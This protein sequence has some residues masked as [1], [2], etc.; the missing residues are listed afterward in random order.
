MGGLKPWLPAVFW[1][2]VIFIF[3]T[4]T[5]SGSHTARFILPALRWLVPHA[6]MK[7]LNHLHFLIR[8]GA[9]FTEYF[10]F[11]LL[12]LRGIR[13]E[14]GG[15]KLRWALA[16]VAL[17]AC[18]AAL[19]EVHQAFVPSRGPSAWDSLLDTSAAGAAQV[20]AWIWARWQAWRLDRS[21]QGRLP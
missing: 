19:D 16:A 10:I 8:K 3:S 12:V 2:I 6:S 11:S 9:H 13:G 4:D 7:T 21:V 15:W 18:Y 20:M 5:F 1:A 17:A 14:R